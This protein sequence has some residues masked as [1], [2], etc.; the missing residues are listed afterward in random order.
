MT[1][2]S[3][4]IVR[5]LQTLDLVNLIRL[6]NYGRVEYLQISQQATAYN[7]LSRCR[8]NILILASFLETMDYHSNRLTNRSEIY[9]LLLFIRDVNTWKLDTAKLQ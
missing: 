3:R 9:T 7:V 1:V 4:F 6:Y 2:T 8:V 5:L